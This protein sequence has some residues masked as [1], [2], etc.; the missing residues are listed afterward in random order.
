MPR[1]RDLILFVV[2]A[3]FL[4]GAIFFTMSQSTGPYTVVH[5]S[6]EAA[7]PAEVIIANNP[8]DIDRPGTI[9]RLQAKILSVMTENAMQPSVT[10]EQE[11]SAASSTEPDAEV[12]SATVML[13]RCADASDGLAIAAAWPRDGVAVSEINGARTVTVYDAAGVVTTLLTLPLT[14]SADSSPHCLDS[15]VVGVTLDGSLIFNTDAIS[16]DTVPAHTFIGYA[17]DGVPIYGQ[18]DGNT[19]SCG[20]Y[21]TGSG[22]R[23]GLSRERTFIIGCFGAAPQ[24]FSIR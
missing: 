13:K 20:G 15:E 7:P 10:A 19:D 14:V 9:A 4:F 11:P 16:Y 3:L 21:D 17:R 18:Y 6:D 2:S 23:Y 22:Y 1:S 5:F 12:S 8:D 24:P